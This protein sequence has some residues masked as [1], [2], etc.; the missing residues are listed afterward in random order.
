[1]AAD[2]RLRQN[3][4]RRIRAAPVKGTFIIGKS[5]CRLKTVINQYMYQ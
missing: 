3:L 1:M 5:L 4:K 2:C